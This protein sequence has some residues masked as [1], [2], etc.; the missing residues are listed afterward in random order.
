MHS[1]REDGFSMVMPRP[2]SW[3]LRQ[4]RRHIASQMQ[5]NELKEMIS[6]L[7]VSVSLLHFVPPGLYDPVDL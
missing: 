7:S 4:Q 5:H 1:S 2:S 6:K 3:P